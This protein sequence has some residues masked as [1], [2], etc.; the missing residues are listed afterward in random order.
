MIRQVTFGFLISMMSSCIWMTSRL[1]L[2]RRMAM[3]GAALWYRGGVWR[4]RMP[5]LFRNILNTRSHQNIQ[6]KPGVTNVGYTLYL[7]YVFIRENWQDAI[8]ITKCKN[9]QKSKSNTRNV[10]V[11]VACRTDIILTFKN[12]F[13]LEVTWQKSKH[14][15]THKCV[16]LH[17]V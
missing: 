12:D 11:M 1:A 13:D 6:M 10:G 7:L 15:V 16:T 17:Q 5:R 3:R 8:T 14:C 9:R 4:L 2:V